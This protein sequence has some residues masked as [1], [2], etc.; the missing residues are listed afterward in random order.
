ML[1]IDLHN[2]TIA[3]GHAFNTIYEMAESA[4]KKGVKTLG[5]L[6]H[7]PDLA[8]APRKVYFEC[9]DRAPKELFGVKIMY[10]AELN[11]KDEQGTLDLPDKVLQRLD[12]SF[13]FHISPKYEGSKENYTDM[14]IKAMANPNVNIIVHSF[15]NPE[16]TDVE[17]IAQAACDN[18]KLMEISTSLFEGAESIEKN[19][20]SVFSE[21]N[22]RLVKMI[23]VIKKNKCKVLLGSDSHVETEIGIDNVFREHMASLDLADEDIANNDIDYLRKFIKNI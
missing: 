9:L 11:I 3:S 21:W 2:H 20:G 6:E 4:S 18:N 5:I 23:K 10:G 22:E 17:R 15:Y 13:G 7:G 1:K 14:I 8:G 19:W 16:G 12:F